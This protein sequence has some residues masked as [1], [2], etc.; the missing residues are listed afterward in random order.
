MSSIKNKNIN[1]VVLAGGE[2]RRLRPLTYYF[3]KCMAPIGTL[4]KPMLEYIL[5]LLK[6]H[7]ITNDTLL[8]GYKHNQI[9]NYFNNGSRFGIKIQYFLDDTQLPGSGGALINA[10]NQS[11]FKDTN[12]LLIYYGDIISDINLTEMMKQHQ[13][14]NAIATLA[15]VEEYQVPVGVAKL[16]H[17]K[18]IQWQEKPKI[19]INA[20]IGILALETQALNHLKKIATI[21]KSIDI[22]GDLIPLML[23]NNEKIE[24]YITDAYWYDLGSTEKYEKIDN[25]F[26]DTLLK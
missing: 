12:T 18:I 9:R 20:G 19:D 6:K 5:L 22:M 1:G 13:D 24:A 4:Q 7:D 2:G 17:N 26:V 8:V 10:A 3:Q 15:V 25:G 16:D 14:N 11:A 23:K 21:K